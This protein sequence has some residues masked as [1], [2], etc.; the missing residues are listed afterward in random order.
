M[1]GPDDWYGTL[2]RFHIFCNPPIPGSERRPQLRAT[3]V[4]EWPTGVLRKGPLCDIRG[5]VLA[6][7]WLWVNTNRPQV[8][9]TVK[10]L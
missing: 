10:Q 2:D 3:N 9:E 4:R 8:I 5:S 6:V 1:T 7:G